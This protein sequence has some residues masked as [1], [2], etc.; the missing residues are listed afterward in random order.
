MPATRLTESN[1]RMLPCPPGTDRIEYFDATKCAPPGFMLRVTANARAKG[2]GRWIGR[3]YALKFYVQGSKTR[4]RIVIGDVGDITLDEARRRADEKSKLAADGKDP[5]FIASANKTRTIAAV[6]TDYIEAVRPNAASETVSGYERLLKHVN[7]AP[8]LKAPV[9]CIEDSH[10]SALLARLG[11]EK[12]RYLANRVFNLIASSLRWAR[13]TR[14]SRKKLQPPT[15]EQ[16]IARNPCVEMTAPF[17]EEKRERAL[18]DEE[19]LR[20]WRA[21]ET[22]PAAVAAYIRLLILTGLRR[23][24]ASYLRWQDYSQAEKI[25][26]VPGEHRKGG[27]A[28]VVFLA[29]LAVDILKSLA[30]AKGAEPLFGDAGARFRENESRLMKR[31]KRATEVRDEENKRKVVVPALEFRLHDLRRTC[32]TGCARTGADE[33][34]ISRILGHAVFAKALPVT[35]QYVQHKYAVEHRAALERWAAH[36]DGLLGIDR[37]APKVVE[38]QFGKSA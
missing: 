4:G 27:R 26:T 6:C 34:M 33:T 10:V 19:V 7:K 29:P 30:A 14:K 18:S 32:A 37:A 15:P 17:N 22:Q 12:G 35:L 3:S 28:H 25:L 23:N 36:L 31:I 38:G 16:R 2:D 5:R 8:E 20:V 24:E 11:R 21:L 9:D 13:G 1:V